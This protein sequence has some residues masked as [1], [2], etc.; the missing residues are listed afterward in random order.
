MNRAARSSA[1]SWRRCSQAARRGSAR[2]SCPVSPPKQF[3]TSITGAFEG[4]YDNPDGSHS[5]LVGY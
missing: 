4:W 2:A 3:G 5:F 1:A